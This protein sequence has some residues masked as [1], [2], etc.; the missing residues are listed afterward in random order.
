MKISAYILVPVLFAAFFAPVPARCAGATTACLKSRVSS[1]KGAYFRKVESVPGKYSAIAATGV[2]PELSFDADRYHVPKGKEPG[3]TEGPLDRPSVYMG[4]SAA[5]HEV[6]CGLSLDRVYDVSGAPAYTDSPSLTDGGD[7]EHRLF[8]V[9]NKLVDANGRV[10]DAD[11][12]SI[13]K[14][15][16]TGALRG[17]YAFRPFWRTTNMEEGNL[18]HNP[19]IG[20]RDNVY[21]YPGERIEM[22]L[23]VIANG[24]VVLEINGKNNFSAAF[25]QDG[26]SKNANFTFKRVNSID[27]FR[28]KGNGERGGNEGRKVMATRTAARNASWESAALTLADGSTVPLYGPLCAEI[29]GSDTAAGYGRI[30]SVSGFSKA[31]GE[32]INI[33]P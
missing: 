4:G 27:Q 10:V 26:F 33:V 11:A 23:S 25:N 14:K 21:F 19:K 15:R 32:T 1:A 24:N 28:E 3:Y 17:D 9:D 8:I 2:L 29:R 18:W 30:F 7:P 31:G 20:T 12:A 22:K 5:G 16:K 6:D 13:A